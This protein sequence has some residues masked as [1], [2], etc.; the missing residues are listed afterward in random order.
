M[1][2]SLNVVTAARGAHNNVSLSVLSTSCALFSHTCVTCVSR[3]CPKPIMMSLS[4]LSR[5]QFSPLPSTM[6]W[7]ICLAISTL[8]FALCSLSSLLQWHVDVNIMN[9]HRPKQ[10]VHSAQVQIVKLGMPNTQRPL[11]HTGDQNMHTLTIN[12][13]V[14]SANL[15]FSGMPCRTHYRQ[16]QCLW[17]LQLP[18]GQSSDSQA[19]ALVSSGTKS[20]QGCSI[21]RLLPCSIIDSCPVVS[22]NSW[23]VVACDSCPAVSCNSWPV[24]ACDS[25]PAVSCN[26]WPVVA[27]DSCP[28][29]SCNSWP[30]VACDSC[31]AVSCNSWPVVACD[32]CPA[33]SCNSWP[34]ACCRAASVLPP[35]NSRCKIELIFGVMLQFNVVWCIR[36]RREIVL[37]IQS[38]NGKQGY[39]VGRKKYR[40]PKVVLSQRPLRMV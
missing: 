23:P 7:K 11:C 22:C 38:D 28:A 30:V 36:S 20:C 35:W 5:A 25:C 37:T 31:P 34:V 21:L 10:F 12:P 33:V 1:V 15:Y 16:L 24:V 14:H 3:G 9:I 29:V 18:K 6:P 32:S 17:R 13:N 4:A 26:S 2:Q 40:R 19:S 8:A 27:C 39:K